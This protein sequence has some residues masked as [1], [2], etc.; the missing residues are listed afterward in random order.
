MGLRV[1]RALLEKNFKKSVLLQQNDI[2]AN[3]SNRLF[4]LTGLTEPPFVQIIIAMIVAIVCFALKPLGTGETCKLRFGCFYR[5]QFSCIAVFLLLSS[6]FT[7]YPELLFRG[8]VERSNGNPF[9][10]IQTKMV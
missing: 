10:S 6:L 2:Y 8:T 3:N 1:I 5:I 7:M 9:Q 4:R